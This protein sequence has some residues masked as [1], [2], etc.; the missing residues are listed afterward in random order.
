M[1]QMKF[2]V[3]LRIIDCLA[4]L[5]LLNIF[6]NEHETEKEENVAREFF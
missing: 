3:L 6:C 1:L 4:I 2:A 5:G